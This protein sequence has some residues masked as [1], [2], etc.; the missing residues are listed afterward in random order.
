MKGMMYINN[1]DAYEAYG[2]VMRVGCDN[3]LLKLPV[4]KPGYEYNWGDEDGVE[5][6]PDEEAVYEQ[7]RYSLPMTIIGDNYNDFF[8]KY[9]QLTD[10]LTEGEEFDLDVV[11]LRRRFKVRYLSMTSLS[12]LTSFQVNGKVACNIILQLTDNYPTEIFNRGVPDAPYLNEITLNVSDHP[13]LTWVE[14]A[15]GETPKTGNK[16]QRRLLNGS[17]SDIAE[18]NGSNQTTFTDTTALIGNVYQYRV[19]TKNS[20]GYGVWSNM[21][22]VTVGELPLSPPNIYVQATGVGEN[23]ITVF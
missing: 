5:F 2:L 17:Y 13:V 15:T 3:E 14:G 16:I 23:T 11:H 18:I 9:N 8:S 4:R 6:D 10:F 20:A 22:Q 7:K 12:K 1:Q 19:A 21:Q